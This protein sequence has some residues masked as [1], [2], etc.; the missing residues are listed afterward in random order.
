[1]TSHSESTSKLESLLRDACRRTIRLGL[2]FADQLRLYR[3]VI[4]LAR[5]VR[6]RFGNAAPSEGSTPLPALLAAICDHACAL[7]LDPTLPLPDALPVQRL[8]LGLSRAARMAE[9]QVAARERLTAKNPMQPEAAPTTQPGLDRVPTP[10]AEPQ[11]R[12]LE[13]TAQDPLHREPMPTH[14]SQP[15]RSAEPQRREWE[16]TAQDPL[17]REPMPTGASQPPPSAKPKRRVSGKTAQNP[18]HREPMPTDSRSDERLSAWRRDHKSKRDQE[19]Y[20]KLR[21]VLEERL[22][23]PA[24][25]EGR[26]LREE[27]ALTTPA[28]PASASAPPYGAGSPPPDALFDP[29]SAH[30]PVPLA[31]E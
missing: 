7:G 18:L 21:S 20:E 22:F 2:T 5:E 26:R 6:L 14:A 31:A 25:A 11:R 3:S 29:A 8:A 15:P 4:A 9:G 23:K 10:S 28:S 27:K 1:M 13:K 16:K 24:W 30:P 12:E 17:H 19:A